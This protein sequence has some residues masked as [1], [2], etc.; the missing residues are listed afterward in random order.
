[1][2]GNSFFSMMHGCDHARSCVNG[3]TDATCTLMFICSR[4]I[5]TN[6]TMT[7]HPPAAAETLPRR[8]SRDSNF[9]SR[10]DDP[11]GGRFIW[12]SDHDLEGAS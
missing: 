1:M 2:F 5:H 11:V 6:H 3:T 4:R 8:S 10:V 9:E 7:R 12:K